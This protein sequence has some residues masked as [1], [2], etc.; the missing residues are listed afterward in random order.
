MIFQVFLKLSWCVDEL[1]KPGIEKHGDLYSFCHPHF[2]D[3][4]Y[5]F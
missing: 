1:T 5:N 4:N 3:K 2:I